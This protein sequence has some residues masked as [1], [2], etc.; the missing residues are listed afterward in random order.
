MIDDT[1]CHI[2]RF[3]VYPHNVS[4]P[5]SNKFNEYQNCFHCPI[6]VSIQRDFTFRSTHDLSFCLSYIIL[7]GSE[8][9]SGGVGRPIILSLR[10]S[11]RNE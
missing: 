10:G 7:S 5:M 6:V 2:R 1:V 4:F 9:Q 8:S 3:L 11:M